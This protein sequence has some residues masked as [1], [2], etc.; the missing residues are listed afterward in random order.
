M[1]TTRAHVPTP[2]GAAKQEA[3]PEEGNGDH[4][5]RGPH[6]ERHA[7]GARGQRE[8]EQ[9]E[10]PERHARRAA[11]VP[12]LRPHFPKNSR[13]LFRRVGVSVA[14]VFEGLLGLLFKGLISLARRLLL[15]GETALL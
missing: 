2:D 12:R 15:P 9:Q 1:Q 11:R 5:R 3:E 13:G 6:R 14:G 10:K 8:V 7:H 4:Q